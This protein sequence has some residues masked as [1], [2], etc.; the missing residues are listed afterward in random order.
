M[1]IKYIDNVY[2]DYSSYVATC[3]NCGKSSK[4]FTMAEIKK[5]YMPDG[6]VLLPEPLRPNDEYDSGWC[7]CK[8]CDL[9]LFHT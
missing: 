2:R 9:V 1:T 6:W 5:W 7:V 4:P 8:E 3:D